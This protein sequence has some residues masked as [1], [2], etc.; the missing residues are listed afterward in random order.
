MTGQSPIYETLPAVFLCPH[1]AEEAASG[2]QQGQRLQPWRKL[3]VGGLGRCHCNQPAS[4][5]YIHVNDQDFSVRKHHRNGRMESQKDLQKNLPSSQVFVL[6]RRILRLPFLPPSKPCRFSFRFI[7]SARLTKSWSSSKHGT[8][9]GTVTKELVGTVHRDNLRR[10][11]RRFC[12][13]AIASTVPANR[14]WKRRLVLQRACLQR[15]VRCAWNPPCG[16]LFSSRRQRPRGPARLARAGAPQ[17]MPEILLQ[18]STSAALWLINYRGTQI[19][20]LCPGARCHVPAHH[21]VII[22]T[23]PLNH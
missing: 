22:A 6:A 11:A 23:H 12:T 15:A 10:F 20:T 14:C 17:E 21:P 4:N 3:R 18:T 7:Q 8:A 2:Q 5:T 16:G 13:L 9:S 19:G 1:V